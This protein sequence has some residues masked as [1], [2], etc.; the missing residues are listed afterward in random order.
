VLLVAGVAQRFQVSAA[1]GAFLVRIAVSGPIAEQSHRLLGSLR[2][3]FAAT[4]FFFFGLEIDPATLTPALPV[5]LA[6][7][8]VTGATKVLTGYWAAGMARIETSED[9]CGRASNS[10]HA[11]S[12]LLSLLVWA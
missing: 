12:S 5:A 4:F 3:L 2:D 10:L 1:I 9:V 7:G 8:F 6:L 11:A